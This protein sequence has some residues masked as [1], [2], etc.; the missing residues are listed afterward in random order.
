M[1]RASE[2]FFETAQTL[3]YRFNRSPNLAVTQ[4]VCLSFKPDFV[5]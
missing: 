1:R 3:D 2:G 5:S 4:L